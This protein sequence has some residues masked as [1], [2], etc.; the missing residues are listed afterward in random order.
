MNRN[1]AENNKMLLQVLDWD[2]R[3][4]RGV[5][6]VVATYAIFRA[7]LE[8]SIIASLSE[9]AKALDIK[10]VIKGHLYT[11]TLLSDVQNA[12]MTI[13]EKSTY[14]NAKLSEL[15]MMFKSLDYNLEEL[16]NGVDELFINQD[17]TTTEC[18][19][20][21]MIRLINPT[22]GD[23]YDG[24]S[25]FGGTLLA[26]Y[27][28]AKAHGKTLSLYGQE[29]ESMTQKMSV[30]RFYVLGINKVYLE[31]G[32]VIDHPA[33]TEDA[34]QLKK[35]DYI[36]MHVPWGSL[37]GTPT[38]IE[39]DPFGR[40]IYGTPGRQNQELLFLSHALASL[41]PNGKAA[42]ILPNGALFKSGMEERIR[43]KLIESDL[44]EAVIG[45]PEQVLTT[46]PLQ[47]SLVLFNKN[48]SAERRHNIL[49]INAES[50]VEVNRRQ[51]L[52]SD[53][54][55]NQIVK[56]VEQY[57]TIEDFSKEVSL[58]ELNGSNLLVSEYLVKKGIEV[59]GYGYVTFNL[60]QA[61]ALSKGMMLSDVATAYRGISL[62]SRHVPTED[63]EYAVINLSNVKNG[64]VQ[65]EELECYNFS[66]NTRVTGYL[67]QAGDLIV[68]CRGSQLKVA[69]VPKHDRPILVSHNFIG[70]RLNKRVEATYLKAYLESPLG[71]YFIHLK[72]TGTN[73]L[74]LHSRQLLEIP[75]ILPAV[76][77]QEEIIQAHIKKKEELEE[78]LARLKQQ[79]RRNELD[80]FDNMGFGNLMN[81]S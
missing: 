47:F 61:I 79:L 17:Y 63:G 68:S 22:S 5:E 40:F 36:A 52:I 32:D 27:H 41:K 81:F 29:L 8:G 74:T 11:S 26:A 71:Q 13:V 70:L 62:T 33:F 28:Y 51:R 56:A 12:I 10:E 35:F 20:E 30:L 6:E 21:L 60:E 25:G 50:T 16:G 4:N 44:I 1:Y 2:R 65:L 42:L 49:F 18:V 3:S 23:F 72:R 69:I 39:N 24:T 76:N 45:I 67:A 66:T 73:V 58:N 43:Q 55:L 59:E 34:T 77:Q 15:L 80:L 14:S 48:K 38:L 53:V 31:G 64:E 57:Q 9:I 7:V 37:S 46:R 78:E 19:N 75:L 54:G